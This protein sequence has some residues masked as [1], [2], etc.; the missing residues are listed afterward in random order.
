MCLLS[1]KGF[2]EY[3]EVEKPDIVAL[4]ETK[5]DEKKATEDMVEGYHAYFHSPTAKPGYSGVAYVNL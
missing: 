2:D 4:N 5:F 3:L 1:Q